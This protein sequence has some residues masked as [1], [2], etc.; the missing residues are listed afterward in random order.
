M[1]AQKKKYRSKGPVIDN[2]GMG[3]TSQL[4]LVNQ[5]QR[6]IKWLVV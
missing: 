6:S 3:L 1:L 2:R 5:M 4:V